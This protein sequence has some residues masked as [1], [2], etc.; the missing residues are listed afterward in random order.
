MFPADD[1]SL[2]A[3]LRSLADRSGIEFIHAIM[4]KMDRPEQAS[5]PR[6]D[7]NVD[8]GA[9]RSQSISFVWQLEQT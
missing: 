9:Y 5:R 3:A 2:V 8:Q 7:P 4:E 6:C 1:A